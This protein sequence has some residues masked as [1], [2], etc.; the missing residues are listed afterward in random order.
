MIRNIWSLHVR[1]DDIPELRSQL[2]HFRRFLTFV[3][4]INKVLPWTK[5]V[6]E[7]PT[8]MRGTSEWLFGYDYGLRANV[9]LGES[10]TIA[11][12]KLMACR[13]R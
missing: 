10:S 12:V 8:V 1:V 2:P 13:S 7:R 3:R 5:N 6:R 9:R 4:Q 11:T